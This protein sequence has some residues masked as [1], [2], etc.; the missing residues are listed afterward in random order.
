MRITYAQKANR[1][2]FLAQTDDERR[3][4]DKAGFRLDQRYGV[5][6]TK[7]PELVS[8]F[9]AYADMDCRVRINRH[10]L[11]LILSRATT[12]EGLQFPSPSNR[13]YL[14][15][16]L[17]GISY[18]LSRQN[19]LIGDDPGLGKTI[20]AV[21][22]INSLPPISSAL[23]ICPATIKI[24]WARELA[25]WLTR[26][27]SIGIATTDY[28]PPTNI[29]IVNYDILARIRCFE[30][31]VKVRSY[32]KWAT[33]KLLRPKEGN[34]IDQRRWDVLV[35]DEAHMLQDNG[36]KRTQV[37]LGYWRMNRMETP[38]IPADRRLFLTGT[39]M[40]NR[41][42]NL[43]SLIQACDREDLG[44]DWEYYGKRYCKLW[45]A[46]WGW[47]SSGADNLEELQ[48]RLRS[49]FMVRRRKPDV[50]KDLPPKRRQ[51]LPL[52][53]SKV[54]DLVEKGMRIF[55]EEKSRLQAELDRRQA[56][57]FKT[58]GDE[59]E[60]LKTIAELDIP[61]PESRSEFQTLAKIRR[62]E[63]LAKIPYTVEFVKMLLEEREKV[64]IFAHHTDALMQLNQA[65]QKV[66][67]QILY[68][69]IGTVE[70]RQKIVD[71]FQQDS[72]R[73]I[74]CVGITVAV[75]F[76][77][78]SA[79]CAVFHERD[80]RPSVVTQAEDRLHR[81]GQRD[82]VEVFHLVF[83]N[84]FDALMSKQLVKKQEVIDQAVG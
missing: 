6:W 7:A 67:S 52:D 8:P 41:P 74:I 22:L 40:V 58:I 73:R 36:A 26:D 68:G 59:A 70:E 17:T 79:S 34:P 32:S 31:E 51:I 3:L 43:W 76:E 69:G 47:D 30:E 28:F 63:S 4:A 29:V 14:P 60:Y 10:K 20:Q 42:E 19:V 83:D 72:K 62:E 44:R 82:S 77:L 9:E 81:I 78:T 33:V 49:S 61:D 45:K 48:N 27:Y 13:S 11:N 35:A 12:A 38:P 37:T 39:P 56:R 21:G 54:A 64:V 1:F 24:K 18:S 71:Q 25:S 53:P 57:L 84:S 16:Q 50:L 2:E 80:W 15:F 23:I 75:G 5:Y 65:F 66:G 55:E 46:P